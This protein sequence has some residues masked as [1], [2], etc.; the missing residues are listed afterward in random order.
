MEATRIGSGKDTQRTATRVTRAIV[1]TTEPRSTEHI[2]RSRAH[3]RRGATTKGRVTR[4]SG[5][6]TKLTDPSHT[7]WT[8]EAITR[9]TTTT[10]ARVITDTSHTGSTDTLIT[11]AWVTTQAGRREAMGELTAA[12]SLQEGL[13]RRLTLGRRSHHG[14]HGA[15][16]HHGGHHSH[17]SY[18]K[19]R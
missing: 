15:H 1:H 2:T 16:G 19:G 3:T 6:G 12:S 11:E 10:P 13:T 17:A 9:L 8:K 18:L 7:T 14:A 5:V 4:R